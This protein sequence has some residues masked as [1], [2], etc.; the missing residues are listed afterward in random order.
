MTNNTI[1][2]IKTK[3]GYFTLISNKGYITQIYPSKIKCLKLNSP[4]HK[5]FEK[6]LNLYLSKK[7]K[8]IDFR[9][10]S[11]GTSFQLKVWN[12][13]KKI[14]YG[15]TKSYLEIAK[16]L[17]TSSRAVGNACSKNT[18]LILI[19]CHRVVCTNG[20]IGGYVMG[21]KIKGFLIKLEAND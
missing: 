12:E 11:N 9:Y 1:S 13:I 10:K 18:C 20:D 19:P 8:N 3:L 21:K 7:L 15:T 5:R 14:K 17:N 16:N 4:L 2:T 6:K